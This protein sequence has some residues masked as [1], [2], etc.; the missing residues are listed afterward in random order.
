MTFFEG[1]A[2]GAQSETIRSLWYAPARRRGFELLRTRTH[3]RRRPEFTGHSRTLTFGAA[4]SRGPLSLD[5]RGSVARAQRRRRVTEGPRRPSST[6]R[7]Q[8]N[9][10]GDAVL[11]LR[12]LPDQFVAYGAGE[13]FGDNYIDG[14]VRSAA[15]ATADLRTSTPA[16]NGSAVRRRSRRST[17]KCRSFTAAACSSRAAY[18]VNLQQQAT[19]HAGQRRRSATSLLSNSRLAQTSFTVDGLRAAS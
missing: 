18:G 7:R 15:P 2:T 12:H 11:T 6:R 19:D 17:A 1:P 8:P 9:G 16:G 13:I 5:R 3:H 4:T 10:G 14:N